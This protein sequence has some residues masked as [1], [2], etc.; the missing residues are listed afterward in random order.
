MPA[1]FLPDRLTGLPTLN[2]PLRLHGLP[3]LNLPLRLRGLP[4]LGIFRFSFQLAVSLPAG[5]ALPLIGMPH[6]IQLIRPEYQKQH[7]CRPYQNLFRNP[8]KQNVQKRRQHIHDG[9][10]ADA[11][12]QQPLRADSAVEI[13]EISCVIPPSDSVIGNL[14]AKRSEILHCTAQRHRQNEFQG[15]LP[16]VRMEKHQNQYA[17]AAV[18]GKPGTVQDAPVDQFSLRDQVQAHLPQP[19]RKGQDKEHHQKRPDGIKSQI[20]QTCQPG[21]LL[22]FRNG[23]KPCGVNQALRSLFIV[24]HPEFPALLLLQDIKF[25]LP[26]GRHPK[27]SGQQL[28]RPLQPGFL[29]RQPPVLLLH[30]PVYLPEYCP[31]RLLKQ[32]KV[33]QPIGL[34]DPGLPAQA[35]KL[36]IIFPQH[37]C[38][39]RSLKQHIRYSQGKNAQQPPAQKGQLQHKAFPFV[40]LH[41][42]PGEGD[43][44][45][46]LYGGILRQDTGYQIIGIVFDKSPRNGQAPQKGEYARHCLHQPHMEPF[47]HLHQKPGPVQRNLLIQTPLQKHAQ[48]GCP[49]HAHHKTPDKEQ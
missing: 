38:L 36:R 22:L 6:G 42:P 31:V 4:A 21:S 14:Q 48:N 18:D 5:N 49:E 8:P 40:P 37:C 45:P 35:A 30:I 27:H 24:L 11:E 2:L 7:H 43:S 28:I 47:P 9:H 20:I 16:A 41:Q 34:R 26:P 1:L 39:V 15:R 46:G 29:R 13:Q 32:I 23:M 10:P 3:A 44:V 17:A 12:D 19:S 33:V 25:P